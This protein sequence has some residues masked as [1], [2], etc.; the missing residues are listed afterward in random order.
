MPAVVSDSSPFVYLA[1]LQRFDLLHTLFD[2]ILIPGAVWRE[3]AVASASN[4]EGLE[5][6][7]AAE[8]GWLKVEEATANPSFRDQGL[9]G[10]GEG[11][12]E[13]ILLALQKSA[14]LIIDETDGRKVATRLGIT[15][16]GTL[17]VLV[18]AKLSG[19]IPELRAELNRLKAETNFRFTDK[20]F[21]RAL[22]SVGES[23]L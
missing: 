16:I 19:L 7:K 10:L 9:L 13:A 18:Q 2:Q 17:G 6:V 15:S 23:V 14:L 4:P 12:R 5:V 11:E 8:A 1:R 3:V 21:E 22:R 20:L